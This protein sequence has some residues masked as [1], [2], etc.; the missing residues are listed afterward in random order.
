VLGTESTGF[1]EDLVRLEA[2]ADVMI[3]FMISAVPP[4]I[5]FHCQVDRS[6]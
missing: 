3:S 2:E 4:K 6:S 1:V 5:E